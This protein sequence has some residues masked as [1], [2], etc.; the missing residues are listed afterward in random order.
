MKFCTLTNK[1]HQS[2]ISLQGV[3]VNVCYLLKRA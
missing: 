3:T 1:L 2:V